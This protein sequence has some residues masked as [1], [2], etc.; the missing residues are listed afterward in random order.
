MVGEPAD[1]GMTEEQAADDVAKSPLHRNG[2]VAA[3]W[4][5][6]V[7][8]SVVRWIVAVARVLGNV[9]APHHG[10]AFERGLEH[11]RIPR[12]RKLREGLPRYAGDGVERVRL[13]RIVHHVVKECAIR[14]G[15]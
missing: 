13:T 15:R 10:R 1:V 9:V 5:M 8:L 6:S 11:L 4:K 12:H 2:Q 7:W 14:R 3:N